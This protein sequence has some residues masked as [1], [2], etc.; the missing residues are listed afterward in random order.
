MPRP[1]S[2]IQNAGVDVAKKSHYCQHN[3][4]HQLRKGDRRL[5][6]SNGRSY[7]YYCVE[8]AL[9]IITRDIAKLQELEGQLKS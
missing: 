1:K 2:I 3:A 8:C 6:V 4:N 7:D 5:K 9:D